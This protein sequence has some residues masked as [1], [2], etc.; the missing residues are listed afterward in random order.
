M[1]IAYTRTEVEI[2][3]ETK[4]FVLFHFTFDSEEW[5]TVK[6]ETNNSEILTEE[7]PQIKF[8][9][10]DGFPSIYPVYLSLVKKMTNKIQNKTI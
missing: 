4:K 3:E 10:R 9:S 8:M 6:Y 7:T 2:S 5:V 1:V